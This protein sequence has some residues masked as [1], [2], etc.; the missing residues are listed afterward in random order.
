MDGMVECVAD[1]RGGPQASA[2]V[3]ALANVNLMRDV[4]K[5]VAGIGHTLGDDISSDIPK[6]AEHINCFDDDTC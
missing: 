4:L 6:M 5:V 2:H 3:E 1:C